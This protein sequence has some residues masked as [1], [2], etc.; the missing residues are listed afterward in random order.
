MQSVKLVEIIDLVLC[1]LLDTSDQPELL[2]VL[3]EICL[4]AE[5]LVVKGECL[6]NDEVSVENDAMMLH[7]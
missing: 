5:L 6:D 2:T 4:T 1:L 3:I 7:D